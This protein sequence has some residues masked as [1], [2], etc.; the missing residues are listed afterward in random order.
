[1]GEEAEPGRAPRDGADTGTERPLSVS[2]GERVDPHQPV[3]ETGGSRYRVLVGAKPQRRV[4]DEVAHVDG[5][6][7]GIATPMSRSVLRYSPAQPHTPANIR[8]WS[9]RSQ[10]SSS[11]TSSAGS[12]RA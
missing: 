3:V 11:S 7:A 1:M 2:V 8:S 12:R 4:G 9:C 10:W 6:P 5:D